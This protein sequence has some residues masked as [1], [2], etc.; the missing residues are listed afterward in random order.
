MSGAPATLPD[1]TLDATVKALILA[2]E[3]G[4]S[5]ALGNLLQ[6]FTATKERTLRREVA[7]LAAVL[8]TG[9][10]RLGQNEQL[11]RMARREMPSARARLQHVLKLTEDAA[12]RTLDL[13]ER[14]RPAAERIRSR[15]SDLAA[16]IAHSAAAGADLPPH[17][18]NAARVASELQATLGDCDEIQANLLEV[19][20]TQGFQDLSGQIIRAVI[21][22]VEQLELALGQ[23]G[24]ICGDEVDV[25]TVQEAAGSG[26]GPVVPGVNEGLTHQQDIDS[27]MKDL[28]I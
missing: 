28:G 10:D 13:V 1:G 26:F 4:D 6:Q 3:N 17:G 21:S 16:Q 22:L 18:T 11:T 7:Q 5:I 19:L 23:L 25:P 20:M 24:R 2:Y 14:S 12:H 27:L 9:L 15:S 8:Q